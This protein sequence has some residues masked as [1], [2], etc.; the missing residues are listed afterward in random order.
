MAE[1]VSSVSLYTNHIW[2]YDSVAG[3][4]ATEI[5]TPENTNFIKKA[6]NYYFPFNGPIL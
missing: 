6:N 1:L 5:K 3:N 2:E 4:W